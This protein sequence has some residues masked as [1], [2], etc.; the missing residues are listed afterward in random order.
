[1]AAQP[2]K[3]IRKSLTLLC[4]GI[5]GDVLNQQQLFSGDQSLLIDLAVVIW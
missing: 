5:V 3:K 1:M 4:I 2:T